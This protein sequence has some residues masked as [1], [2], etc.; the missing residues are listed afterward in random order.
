M[1]NISLADLVKYCDASYDKNLD[2]SKKVKKISNDSRTVDQ[3][4]VY[5]ALIG[6]RLD[7]HDFIE[8]AKENG[9]IAVISQKNEYSQGIYV[10]NSYQALKDI[11]MHYRERFKIPYLAVTGSSGK[12]TSKDM[13]YY[14]VKES[15]KT[16]RNIGN[17]NSEVGLPMTVLNLDSSYEVGILE[18]GMYNLGEID[19]LAEI[20]RPNIG[21]ITNIGNAHIV[22]LKTRDNIL[23]AKMEISN[24]MTSKDYLLI[25]GDDD[26]LRTIKKDELSATVYTFG[27]DRSNDI[28]VLEYMTRDGEI[29]VRAS[30]LGQ[31]IEFI[32]PT[33]G[34][35]NIY[36][37]LSV[38]GACK[39]LNLNLKK[40]AQ[41]LKNYQPS[42][43][44][45]EKSEVNGKL[46]INDSYNANPYSM[47]AA[48]SILKDLSYPRRVVILGDMLELGDESVGEHKEIGALL[49]DYADLIIAIGV[50]AK[51]Y[52][53]GAKEKDFNQKNMFYFANNEEA[54]KEINEILQAGDVVFIKGSRGM[55]LEEVA[56]SIC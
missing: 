37:A 20:V 10:E 2:L 41:G 5:L 22:N 45:M 29:L 15:K 7:G 32:I 13:L 56:D 30:I 39:I 21:I 4:W 11:A 48:I 27:L 46:I 8:Q 17:L 43:Y 26:M 40:S 25:N 12:T 36:N 34:E 3:D 14:A 38:M 31:E 9:A 52:L 44:R 23:K 47:K 42:K 54:I 19:Y 6:E 55:K 33:L 18:M 24:Y 51:N 50:E 16:L 1:E 53:E 49:K 28:H 35:H